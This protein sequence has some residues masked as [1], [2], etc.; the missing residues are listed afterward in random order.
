MN[1][2]IVALEL[3]PYVQTSSAAESVASLAK[4]LR[5]L[6]H[7]VTVAV[8]RLPAYEEAGLMAARQLSPLDCEGGRKAHLF[9]AQLASGITLTLVDVIDA[10]FDPTRDLTGQPAPL[11]AFASAVGALHARQRDKGAP[12]DV[13][14]AHDAGA[15]L[16][17]LK[18]ERE[19]GLARI[20]TVHD[21]VRSGEFSGDAREALG[22]PEERAGAQGFASGDGLCLLKGLAGEA[23]A[24]VTPSESYSRQLQAPEKYGALSRAFQ[25]ASLFS[26]TEGVDHA[27]Y[28]PA[29]DAALVNRFDAPDP[30]AKAKNKVDALRSVGLEFELNRPLVFCEDVANGDVALSTLVSALPALV[31]NDVSLIVSASESSR[32]ENAAA[33]EP[34]SS[35][36]KFVTSLNP[37]TRR[38]MLAASDFYLSLRK[39]DPS[40]QLLLQASRYGAVP[41]AYSVDGV[42]DIVVDCDAEL[43][44]G[45]GILFDTMTQRALV[46]TMG[47]AVLAYRSERFP[48]LVSR[49]M[50]QDL[51]WDRSARRH[52]Q[53][54]RRVVAAH[55]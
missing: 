23:D 3:A 43:K 20:L 53:I 47:R 19:V 31:R 39:R 55:A 9:D 7:D 38:R 49:V 2:L 18:L 15:G 32:A 46:S 42:P 22:I 27:V 11:G 40:G 26:V 21:A 50:R 41:V 16:A 34:L 13:V 29:T 24:I 17:L 28:N 8:P 37:A 35:H 51:A 33:L 25:S 4:A 44:T 36:V 45:T 52:E 6:G 1:V 30:R 12:F 48:R 10:A 54:Y 14:H 5:L